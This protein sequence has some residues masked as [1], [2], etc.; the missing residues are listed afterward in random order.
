MNL[1]LSDGYHVG[2]L[3]IPRIVRPLARPKGKEGHVH[4][5]QTRR[6][7]PP[8]TDIKAINLIYAK[9]KRLTRWMGELY[10]VDH[11]V[12]KIHPLVCGLHV[13]W[14]LRIIHWR[15]NAKKG[16]MW[17]DTQLELFG[18]LS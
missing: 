6:A 8:W 4:R 18:D 3:F 7:T 15:E 9:A 13:E 16:A 14:N 17:P 5:L 10:V 12:P 11:I 1:A 2:P